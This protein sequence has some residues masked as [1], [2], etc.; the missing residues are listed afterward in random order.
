[1]LLYRSHV[2]CLHSVLSFI[3]LVKQ[4]K[5]TLSAMDDTMV[6]GKQVKANSEQ[7]RA[8][9][10]PIAA[11]SNA[12]FSFHPEISLFVYFRSNL[13]PLMSAKGAWWQYGRGMI[14]EVATPASSSTPFLYFI[15]FTILIYWRVYRRT[16][17]TFLEITFLMCFPSFKRLHCSCIIH[18]PSRQYSSL[19]ITCSSLLITLILPS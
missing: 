15:R 9:G 8:D 17:Q 6:D 3:V 2:D 18:H 16:E 11:L 4:G 19:C 5:P 7:V 10:D 1:M 14:E 13:P 12:L